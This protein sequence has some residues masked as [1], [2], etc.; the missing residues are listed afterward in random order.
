MIS[1]RNQAN[2]VLWR[3]LNRPCRQCSALGGGSFFGI[4]RIAVLPE[5][6]NPLKI[7]FNQNI[8]H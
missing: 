7:A 6:K 1:R 3:S 8:G 4:K 5:S 2:C